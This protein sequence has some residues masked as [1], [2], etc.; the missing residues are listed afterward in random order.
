MKRL[1]S[2]LICFIL[3]ITTLVCSVVP[4]GAAEVEEEYISGLRLI[5]ADDYEEATEIL[6]ESEEFSHYRLFKRNLNENSREIGVWLAYEVTTDIDQAITD[7][8]IM[9]M[10]GG[11]TEG[12]YQEMIKES[13]D[14]YVAMGEVYLDAIDYWR[15][16]YDSGDYIADAVYRQLNFYN[17]VSKDIPVNE[18]PAFEGERIGDIFYDGIAKTALATMFMQGNSHVLQNIRSLLAMGVSYNEDGMHYLE[19]V[20]EAAELMNDDYD[21]FEDHDFYD[22]FDDIA[23]LIAGAV[24]GFKD[25][26]DELS[27]DEDELEYYDSEMTE[28]ELKYAEAKSLA[29]RFREITYLD[30]V[31]FY[32]FCMEYELDEEDLTTL[33][34]LVAALNEG[35]L[36]MTKVNHFYDVVRYSLSEYPE[37]MIEAEIAEMEKIYS[38]YPF[39]IYGGVD[40]SIYYGTFA[41]TTEAYRND[42][43]TESGFANFMFKEDTFW[44]VSTVASGAISVGLAAW[45]ICRTVA[46]KSANVS[47]ELS[48]QAAIQCATTVKNSIVKMTDA[49]FS[50][51]SAASLGLGP[52]AGK[53]YGDVVQFLFRKADPYHYTAQGSSGYTSSFKLELIYKEPG[54]YWQ[55]ALNEKE[56]VVLD[57]LNTEL[58]AEI[59]T[60]RQYADKQL[61]ACQNYTNTVTGGKVV[62][63]GTGMLYAISGIMLLYSAF[64]LAMSV[65][66]YYHPDYEDIPLALVDMRETV[67]G[68]RYVKYDV[69]YE[70]ETNDDGIYEAA[71]LNAF[72]GERWNA[73]Y[74]TKS[75]EAGKPL[76]ADTFTLSNTNNKAKSGYTPV[77]RFGEV[78]C[79]DLNKYNFRGSTGIYLSVKQSDKDKS[80][81]ADVPELVGSTIGTGFIFLTGGVGIMLGVG[82][83]LGFQYVAKKKKAGSVPSDREANPEIPEPITPDFASFTNASSVD[84]TEE[85]AE[86]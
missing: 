47:F 71:D 73:M 61:E 18:I 84:V 44:G 67:D 46:A 31:S 3:V 45:A 28:E 30:G 37:D 76:L 48:K 15:D 10:N 2:K 38:E 9:Q 19:R 81:I 29:D 63:F 11:Y 1:Y 83:T 42:A 69:V 54:D 74:Y 39:N 49:A 57:K 23:L 36:A 79:Y 70:A 7:I 51:K 20:A 41:L 8:S 4:V 56:K 68:D 16:A 40:R 35:Q 85:K 6:K 32:D 34:P 26:L 25:M 59:E 5:Y 55:V 78:V 62:G 43:Y 65:H 17:V 60:S 50:A 27:N 33:Y 64:S 72:A 22:E 66:H 12:N 86:D 52:E 77:H 82:G 58:N 21:A 24:L 80:A 13:Y 14:E 53:T 75:Y